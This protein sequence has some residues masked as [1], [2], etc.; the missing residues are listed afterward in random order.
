MKKGG[1]IVVGV[2]NLL[3][4]D[5][6]I[7]IR[8]V[9]DLAERIECLGMFSADGGTGGYSLLGIVEG[10]EQVIFVDAV[11]MGLSPGE[12]QRFRGD[13]IAATVKPSLSGHEFDLGA[14]VN[15]IERIMPESEIDVVGIQPANVD[16]GM[17][18]SEEL[19]GC[20]PEILKR[21]LVLLQAP[22]FRKE[23]LL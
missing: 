9:N 14:T 8:V 5:D 17:E 15:L 21:V 13:R 7:G 19:K 16:Y 1:V 6:G 4:R 20:Y 12:V 18:L 23:G 2:G 3:R 22:A 11:N 10:F